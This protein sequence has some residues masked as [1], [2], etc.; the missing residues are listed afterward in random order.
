[1]KKMNAYISGFEQEIISNIK[2]Y[3][4]V[5]V[6]VNDEGAYTHNV[7]DLTACNFSLPYQKS[8]SIDY[9]CYKQVY[10]H[11]PEF[12]DIHSRSFP[13][14]EMTYHGYLNVFNRLFYYC[15]DL[16]T[17]NKIEC[18]IFS[19]MPHEGFDF[20]ISKI[21]KYLKLP[22]LMFVQSQFPNRF[23]VLH[24]AEDYGI[25]SQTSDYSSAMPFEL[26]TNFDWFYMKEREFGY[27]IKKLFADLLRKPLMFPYAFY[28]Y[29]QAWD[30]S[31]S[32]KSQ[33]VGNVEYE[34]KFVYFPLHLQPE[35][36]TAA[37]GGIYSDQMLAIEQLAQ[38]LPPDWMV[39]VKENPKQTERQRDRVFFQRLKDLS[40][41]VLLP[42]SENS[43]RLIEASQ[44]VATIAGTAGWEAI[45]LGK[46]ALVFGR[47]WYMTLPGVFQFDRIKDITDIVDAAVP[48]REAVSSQMSKL[49][50]KTAIGVVDPAYGVL[51]EDFDSIENVQRI[52]MVLS[53]FLELE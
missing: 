25:F 23:W 14:Y 43:I 28:K 6:W 50:C 45:S 22:T 49:L 36:S 32:F 12:I 17:A 8:S 52:T 51:V 1:M 39:Y 46:K 20:L 27:G 26:Q 34:K 13:Y 4:D 35:L 31:R 11:L 40:N 30:F 47:A 9:A 38:M 24:D 18:L 15:Y 29:K 19:S 3:C 33:I 44:F 53:S 41:V 48:T 21:A 42:K 37:L 5:K 2:E 16:L 7:F 10:S